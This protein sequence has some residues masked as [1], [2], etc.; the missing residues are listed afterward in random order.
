MEDEVVGQEPT[1]EET[2]VAPQAESQTSEET[3]SEVEEAPAAVSEQPTEEKVETE[4]APRAESRIHELAKRAKEAESE[5]A[6]WKQLAAQAQPQ[7]PVVTEDGTY[8]AEQIADVIL[9]KQQA[10]D[11]EKQRQEAA[12]SMRKDIAETLQSHPDLD[13]DDELAEIVYN[14]AAAKG[15]SLK[16][17]ADRI[18][19]RISNE[20]AKAEKKVIAEKALKGNVSSPQGSSVASGEAPKPDI[21][22]MSE[23][24]KAANWGQILSS[25][26]K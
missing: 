13:Q 18:K 23:D 15:I 4:K 1:V 24:E 5:V 14:F 12:K 21:S 2:V 26:Q 10:L 8:S 20:K 19:A 22:K 7:E 25:Y 16:S 11:V 3:P 9:Q 17:A 6:Y